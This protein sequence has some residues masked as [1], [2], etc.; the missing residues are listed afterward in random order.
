MRI[1]THAKMIADIEK[2]LKRIGKKGLASNWEQVGSKKIRIDSLPKPPQ[3]TIMQV[4]VYSKILEALKKRDYRELGGDE[5]R[6]AYIA[7]F[8]SAGIGLK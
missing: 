6:A 2:A 1:K 5:L 3:I 7:G 4:V 8:L